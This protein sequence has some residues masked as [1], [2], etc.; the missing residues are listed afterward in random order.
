M[1][2]LDT[3]AYTP[4]HETENNQEPQDQDEAGQ[5]EEN[6]YRTRFQVP[7]D[8][9]QEPQLDKAVQELEKQV[10]EGTDLAQKIQEIKDLLNQYDYRKFVDVYIFKCRKCEETF[11]TKQGAGV[12]R[13]MNPNCDRT[14]PWTRSFDS[15]EEQFEQI[16]VEEYYGR[17][18]E[19]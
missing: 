8:Q 11:D 7:L 12:H 3:S 18:T 9:W 19:S 17:N 1:T 5:E 16:E 13:S 4:A 10:R 14:E 6:D 15:L 2:E